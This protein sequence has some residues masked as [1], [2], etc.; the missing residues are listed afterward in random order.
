MPDID[1]SEKTPAHDDRNPR[2]QDPED[3]LGLREGVRDVGDAAS[4]AT[5]GPAGEALASPNGQGADP[6][7]LGELRRVAPQAPR[8]P[9]GQ[10]T[11]R[12]RLRRNRGN[13]ILVGLLLFGLWFLWPDLPQS[14]PYI[15]AGLGIVFQIL[16]YIFLA[17]IQFVAI[18]WFLGRGRMYWLQPGETGLT[19]DDVKGASQIVEVARRIVILLR[20]VKKFKE[21]GGEVSRGLL[22]VGPPGT[23][24]S[25]LAQAIAGEAGVPFAYASA[26]SFQNMFF[27]VS[28][29]RV[30]MLYA[31]A[32]KLARK[33]GA[34]IV[35]IDEIDAIGL[36]RSAQGASGAGGFFGAGLGLLNEL[37]LQMDPPAMEHSL[38][39]KFLRKL[40]LRPGRP[41]QPVVLTI[42]ATN[43]PEVLDPALLRPGRFDRKIVVDLPDLDAR[44][45]IIE[46]YLAKVKHEP[47]PIDRMAS[48]TIGYTPVRIKHVIN[49]A[50][51]VAHFAGREAI[52]YQDF[53]AAREVHEFGLRQPIRSMSKEERRRIAYHEAG[54][55][56]AQVKLLKHERI[57][58]AT[59]I[60]HG[61][62]LGFV[63][64]K[65]LEERYLSDKEELLAEIQVFLASRAA[66]KLFLR[67]ELTGV[68][69]DLRQATRIAAAYL[70]FF[71]MGDSLY[72]S[73]AF[74]ELKPTSAQRAEIER[75]LKDQYK[76]VERLLRRHGPA[77]H[78]VA[79]ALV[80]REEL[81]GDEVI[82][83][84]EN[85]PVDQ[86]TEDEREERGI[87]FRVPRP[88]VEPT[89]SGKTNTNTPNTPAAKGEA[90][91][92]G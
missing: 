5:G 92:G 47:M 44:K 79:Q 16:F 1:Q 61:Q 77:V 30:M 35:F 3:P 70:G 9:T 10:A 87:G 18:F 74:N 76:K 21:M 2:A 81:M 45:E 23:G 28:N 84:V 32:R 58:R 51:I 25:Y 37:L 8:R 72:S 36:S 78:A 50:V 39:R 17:I 91:L 73:L 80:E 56:V 40:G 69:D 63:S 38:W 34:A 15:V 68:T 71:G 62:A 42:A 88:Q 49:E 43:L 48:E 4:G 29:L 33:Y 67:T 64:G 86:A 85:A 54:H 66:E 26:P 55:A 52:T 13:F 6:G 7:R 12:E 11:L 83:L 46:Y 27:G 31:K 14:G 60:R 57:V 53:V 20:G 19:F 82:A 41:P 89:P 59:I 75:I 22:L 90:P 65:P 24:K